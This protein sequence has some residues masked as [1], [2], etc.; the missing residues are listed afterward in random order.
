MGRNPRPTSPSHRSERRWSGPSRCTAATRQT[1]RSGSHSSRR[2]LRQH[3]WWCQLAGYRGA[4]TI[5]R[6]LARGGLRERRARGGRRLEVGAHVLLQRLQ[7]FLRAVDEPEQ[8][9][10]AGA[11]HAVARECGEVHD[12]PPVV[13]SVKQD[14]HRPLELARLRQ[15][16]DLEH[17]VQR[18]ETA[19]E[20]HDRPRHGLHRAPQFLH[21]AVERDRRDVMLAVGGIGLRRDAIRRAL[22]GREAPV[23]HAKILG[24]LPRE[25]RGDATIRGKEAAHADLGPA[26]R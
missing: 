7:R 18:S 12:L 22:A 2:D 25:H 15:R 11:D 26:A 20:D 10:I 19:G 4:R 6:A 3:R 23:L 9:E 14:H 8:V 24:A 21:R 13:G 16:Q 1:G 5:S 17:L